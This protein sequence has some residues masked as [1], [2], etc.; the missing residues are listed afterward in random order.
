[1][2]EIGDGKIAE[3]REK[4]EDAKAQ[5]A[6]GEKQLADAKEEYEKTVASAEKDIADAK[7]K[8]EKGRKEYE[9]GVAEVGKNKADLVKAREELEN[10]KAE[11]DEKMA[12]VGTGM[13]PAVMEEAILQGAREWQENWNKVVA[14]EKEI[15]EAEEE[16]E[17]AAA[18][19]ED[20]EKQIA[21]GEKELA[22]GKVTFEEETAKAEKDIEE[23]IQK[24]ADGETEVADAEEKI[25][26]I[27]YPEWYV[28]KRSD[29]VQSFIEYGKDAERI[30]AVG[31]LFPAI[32]FLVA[33]L[34][35]LT[36]MTRMVEEERTQ[37]GTLK[38]LGYSKGAIA[39]KYFLYAIS[40]SLIGGIAGVAVGHISL[41]YVIIKAYRILY[42]GLP[43]P[44]MPVEWTI[45]TVS[46][47]IAV[48]S[49]VLAALLACYAELSGVPAEL[50]RPEAPKVGKRVFLE[51]LP[52][53]WKHFSFTWKSTV[54]NLFRYKKRLFMTMFGIGGCMALLMV[55]FG[56]RD[57]IQQIVDNQ[58]RTI[59]TYDAY[60]AV[61]EKTDP[62][63]VFEAR[64]EIQD[65][66]L[67]RVVSMDAE[68]N[69]VT[70]NVSLMIPETTENFSDFVKLR[71]RVSGET[72]AISDRG[73][74]ISEKLAKMLD[75]KVG[76]TLEI[77]DGGMKKN[78]LRVDIITENYLYYYVYVTKGYYR[79]VFGEEPLYNQAMLKLSSLTEE[80]K[81]GLST[82]ILA[83]D[84]ILTY[85]DVQSLE[86][87]VTNMMHSLD[88]VIWVLIISAGLLAFVVLYNLNNISILERKREL[89]TLKVLGF[90]DIEVAEYVYRENI[91]LTI[92]GVILGIGLGLVLH[93]FVIR[94]CEI[95]MI[96]FGRRIKPLS[97][98]WSTLLTFFFAVIVNASMFYR[99]RKV[100]MVE[101][102]K[103]AE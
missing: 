3:V 29:S 88:L 1:I 5:I 26:E 15:A 99:L 64:E 90:Y 66:L 54:R 103:S 58:Y 14:G 32:F 8:L 16:L 13:L 33:A 38:A 60:L 98:L 87:K 81:T 71:D 35:S 96:M 75:I 19:L 100:D 73:A 10:A 50:M 52:A 4:L 24:V 21:D 63:P 56:L 47:I 11:L 39:S 69:G 41:P 55:G 86:K 7:E 67:A 37:I 31:K 94:T 61:D 28:L 102:L 43:E 36:T 68:K 89:A 76:D 40:A 80:E 77:S 2:R 62:S 92:L 74:A 53:I 48:G 57:S 97:Y 34:V 51:H 59:W 65:F 25:E 84:E 82:G 72:F 85:S 78:T 93:Q 20:A 44:I 6:D 9:D 46:V 101:S 70:K 22:D 30:G 17:K 27:D 23:G 18:E 42:I 83:N 91:L 45:A 12:L 95:D 79:E 49:T